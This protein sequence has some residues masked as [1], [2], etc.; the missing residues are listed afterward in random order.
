[1]ATVLASFYPLDQ[2]GNG[3]AALQAAAVDL[4][5]AAEGAGKTGSFR[6]HETTF[7]PALAADI[8]QQKAPRAMGLSLSEVNGM[9]S[10]IFSWGAR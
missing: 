4:V 6:G 1:M 8:D 2:A 10:V 7:R 5:A 3:P 9:L